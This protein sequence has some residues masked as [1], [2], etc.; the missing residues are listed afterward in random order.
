MA[1]LDKSHP[2]HVCHVLFADVFV[3]AKP[4]EKHFE[5]HACNCMKPS[6]TGVMGCTEGCLNRMV[7]IECTPNVCPCGDQCSNQRMQRHQWHKA[8]EKFQTESRGYGVRV[9]APVLSGML[10]KKYEKE[11]FNHLFYSC[12]FSKA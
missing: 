12:N 10:T 5:P 4:T 2:A 9:T 7:F 6:D 3:D 8:V 1:Y 11:A